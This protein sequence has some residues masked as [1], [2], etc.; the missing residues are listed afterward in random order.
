MDAGDD[1]HP[2]LGHVFVVAG[3][4]SEQFAKLV[5]PRGGLTVD[6]YDELVVHAVSI[7]QVANRYQALTGRNSTPLE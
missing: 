1:Q 5:R 3:K 2:P 6:R 4:R 7:R